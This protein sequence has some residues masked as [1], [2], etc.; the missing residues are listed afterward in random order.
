MSPG[1]NIWL[2]KCFVD[3]QGQWGLKDSVDIT[4]ETRMKSLIKSYSGNL[5]KGNS[6]VEDQQVPSLINWFK[7][8]TSFKI[9]NC[10]G[11]L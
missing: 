10:N 5:C 1:S 7:I 9:I 6:F 3:C 8:L 2:T 11:R 4:G